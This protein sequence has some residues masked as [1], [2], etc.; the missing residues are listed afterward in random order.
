[1]GK[2]TLAGPLQQVG[3]TSVLEPGQRD[4]LVYFAG[5][6]YFRMSSHPE[7][8]Q[9]LRRALTDY[10]LNVAASRKT[11]GNHV[12]YGELEQALVSFFGAESATL[13][14]NGYMANLGAAQALAGEFTI[15][16]IDE[17]AHSSLMEAARFLECPIQTYPHRDPAQVA[18]RV[19]RLKRQDRPLLI[20]DG[21]FA[22][23][24]EVAPLKELLRALP[25]RARILLDDAH[26]AGLLGRHGRGTL[27][28]AGV[29][30]RQ[31]IQTVTLS[32]AFGVYGGA[33]LGPAQLR[34]QL[35]ERSRLFAGNTPLP[36]PLAAAALASLSALREDPRPRRR[37]I[38]NAAYVKSALREAG[39]DP[40]EG[41]GPIIPIRPA[42][43]RAAQRLQSRLRAAGIH[44]PFINYLGKPGEG[45][46]RFVISSE[47]TPEQL[48]TLIAVL[49]A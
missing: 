37:L 2:A 39:L 43:D 24:G 23:S 13:F 32:K 5:C 38:F 19:R 22:Q 47:H 33:V 21:L 25:A 44:P 28:H 34:Q 7:V 8:L 48:E 41:P 4:R 6:D 35:I 11:T 3:R 36:L 9:A 18:R 29:S 26:G 42:N 49:R 27:E 14:S 1:M 17:R 20:T 40:G 45:Y 30:R 46:F 31:V 12:L 16:L 15:A 10:G